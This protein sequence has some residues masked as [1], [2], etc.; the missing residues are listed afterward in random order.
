MKKY[1]LTITGPSGPIQK[2][3]TDHYQTAYNQYSEW[4][5]MRLP[6]EVSITWTNRGQIYREFRLDEQW[7]SDTQGQRET[8]LPVVS[9]PYKHMEKTRV[10]SVTVPISLYN[11]MKFQAENQGKRVSDIALARLQAV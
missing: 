6:G 5:K 7:D 10:L 8:V 3:Q 2:A 1:I 9:G 11:D 4:R